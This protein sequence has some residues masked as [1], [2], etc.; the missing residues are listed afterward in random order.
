MPNSKTPPADTLTVDQAR[1]QARMLHQNGNPKGAEPLYRAILNVQPK[2]PD[3]NQNSKGNDKINRKQRRAAE[4]MSKKDIKKTGQFTQ[5]F[6]SNTSQRFEVP[7]RDKIEYLV[8]LFNQS[9]FA[10]AETLARQITERFP[11]HGFGWKALGAVI[12]LQGRTAESLV[13][14]Q[15]AAALMS[16][17]AETHNNLGATFH[18]LGQLDEACVCYRRALDLQPDYAE[19]HYNYGENLFGLGRLKEAEACFKSALELKPA[20]AEAYNNLG[21]TLQQLFRLDEAEACFRRILEIKPDYVEALNNF[22]L[23]LS[24]QK[25]YREALHIIKMSLHARE[26]AEAKSA[27]IVSAKQ[28]HFAYDDTELLI[29]ALAEPW[30]QLHE[31][32]QISSATVKQHPD[33]ARCVGLAKDAWPFRLSALDLFGANGLNSLAANPLL[34]TLLISAPICDIDLERFLTMMRNTMLEVTSRI[35]ACDSTTETDL[36][37]YCAVSRQCFIN[38]YLFSHTDDEIQIA[39]N[40]RDSLVAVLEAGTRVP[41]LLPVIVAAYFPLSSLSNAVRLL[42]APW[43]E[44]VRALLIQ[45]ISEPIEEQQLRTTIPRLTDIEDEVS[46][47]VQGQYE[48]NPYPRWIKAAPARKPLSIYGYLR[49]KFPLASIRNNNTKYSFDVL[50]AGCGTGQ[51]SIQS[52]RQFQGAQVLAVDLSISSLCYAVRKTRELGM[53]SIEYAQADL[54]MMGT[55]GRNFDVIESV[56]VLH[57]L[58]DPLLGWRVLSSLLRSGGFMKL[59]FYSEV[60]RR[61]IGKARTYIAE[62]GYGATADAIRRCRQDLV[63]SFT[64]TE[65][66]SILK[67]MDFFSVSSCRDL[68]FHV[69]EQCLT[70]T[71]IA[72]FLKENNLVFV[73]FEMDAD[74]LHAYKQRFP[75][76]NAATDLRQWQIFENENPETFGQMYQFWIQKPEVKA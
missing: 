19:A 59:G 72:A 42:N 11:H 17:D 61:T 28:L 51:H 52:A 35:M 46:L 4:M 75:E 20:Y 54:L 58:A 15:K 2:H 65:F 36:S 47:L 67:S 62:Q 22:A 26:S 7:G 43:P 30:G 44:A 25:K 13:P 53:S 37:L 3:V 70:L 63:D 5:P 60:A 8:T 18:D 49:Q 73:G 12:K 55:L 6:T 57:H 31:L 27:F 40:L 23:L 21:V 64:G 24:S 39:G 34:Q 1:T 68:L 66:E 14:M 38:E 74:I 45:Q 10:E 33:I 48:I 41:I 32:A 69:Q 29:R 56:G 76:D 16:H 9:R 50:I 71:T